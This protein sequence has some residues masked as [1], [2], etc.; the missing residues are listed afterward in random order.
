MFY[1]DNLWS[2]HNS[3][4]Y[5]LSSHPV[6]GHLFRKCLVSC[7][8]RPIFIISARNVVICH[9]ECVCSRSIF[10][11]TYC[12][13]FW[14]NRSI[15]CCL[16]A[17]LLTTTS[18]TLCRLRLYSGFPRFDSPRVEV[19]WPQWP[20]GRR[21]YGER[22]RTRKTRRRRTRTEGNEEEDEGEDK[23]EPRTT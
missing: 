4:A 20:R 19:E 23:M 15:F 10:V 2:D 13:V 6:L 9:W 21:R 14:M 12:Y 17:G 8:I 5:I 1:R 11:C 3:P 7:N 18:S 22:C 16:A